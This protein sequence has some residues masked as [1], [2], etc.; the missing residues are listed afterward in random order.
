MD[1]N[2]SPNW[3]STLNQV[4]GVGLSIVREIRRPS[5]TSLPVGTTGVQVSSSNGALQVSASPALAIG[6]VVAVVVVVFLVTR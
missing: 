1:T 5:P 6:A 3:L 2:Q 4:A